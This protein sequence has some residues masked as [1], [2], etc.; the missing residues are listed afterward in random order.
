MKDS[1]PDLLT[2]GQVVKLFRGEGFK[3]TP[4]NLDYLHRQGIVEAKN[5]AHLRVWDSDAIRKIRARLVERKNESHDTV[6]EVK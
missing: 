5:L 6:G 3:F 2:S 1:T 4:A